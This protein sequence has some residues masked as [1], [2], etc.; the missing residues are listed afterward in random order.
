MALFK[1][2]HTAVALGIA[3]AVA[4]GAC[5]QGLRPHEP[6]NPAKAQA[7]PTSPLTIQSGGQSLGFIVELATTEKQRDIGLMHRNYLA[8]DRGMLF[9]FQKEERTRFWMR[10]TFIPLD[11]LFIRATGEI[12][13]IAENTVPH[14]EAPVG[15]ARPVR[16]VLELPGGTAARLGVKPGDVVR[17]EIFRNFPK[18]QN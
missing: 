3:L 17:H 2:R 14:S 5:A 15:P 13:A 4:S 18:N 11:M 7:L 10:N 6:L 12:A 1:F 8:P 16:A 9:D